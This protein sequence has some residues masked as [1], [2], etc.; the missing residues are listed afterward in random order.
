MYPRRRLN[1]EGRLCCV[2]VGIPPIHSQFRSLNTTVQTQ[3]HVRAEIR[4]TMSNT[5]SQ[6]KD[7]RDE[8]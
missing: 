3:S 6:E 1:D 5:N 7:M 8:R 2:F 4:L